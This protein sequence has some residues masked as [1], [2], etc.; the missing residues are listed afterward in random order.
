MSG[1]RGGTIVLGAPAAVTTGRAV[2]GER[3]GDRLGE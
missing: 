1:Q 3:A 2:A